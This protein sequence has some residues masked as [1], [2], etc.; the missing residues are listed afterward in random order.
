VCEFPAR[1]SKHLTYIHTSPMCSPATFDPEFVVDAVVETEVVNV[2]TAAHYDH[3]KTPEINIQP[4]DNPEDTPSGFRNSATLLDVTKR[5]VWIGYMNTRAVPTHL[6]GVPD[7]CLVYRR[8][9]KD[10]DDNNK[11]LDDTFAIL[12]TP[13]HLACKL[14][15]EAHELEITTFYCDHPQYIATDLTD[16]ATPRAGVRMSRTIKAPRDFG[17]RRW[18]ADTGCG[19]DLVQTSLVLKGGGKAYI[20]MRAPKY[21]NTADGLTSIT[22]EMTMCIPQLDEMAEMLCCQNTPAVI[23]IGKRCLEMGCAFFWPPFSER[24]FFIKPDRTRIFMDVESNIPYL[25]G[26]GEDTACAGEEEEGPETY[27]ED[28]NMPDMPRDPDTG[29]LIR[30]RVP[31]TT[32]VV[33]DDAAPREDNV[34]QD[35]DATPRGD[36][37]S[38]MEVYNEA[39]E[40]ES[41]PTGVLPPDADDED[42]ELPRERGDLEAVCS[43]DFQDTV[44]EAFAMRHLATQKPKLNTIWY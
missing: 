44:R 3:K 5:M 8:I 11:I 14:C 41:L 36:E 18:L 43:R 28:P 2:A 15:E 27:D 22:K 12:F 37:P 32:S 6:R 29:R 4:R 31:I 23:S 30:Q 16:V 20:R 21:L 35:D 42:Q 17:I 39:E 7:H 19:R 33:Q 13:E 9:I 1:E 26:G 10:L 38:E 25:N 24:P 40:I 34:V